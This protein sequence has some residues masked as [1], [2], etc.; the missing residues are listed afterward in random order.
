MAPRQILL[1]P[2]LG[3][4]NDVA[5]HITSARF[6]LVLL[7]YMTK[8]N[9]RVDVQ[10]IEDGIPKNFSEFSDSRTRSRLISPI[11]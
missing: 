1:E 6:R 8:R 5:G 3:L 4:N 10:K 7:F 2:Y 9:V 11:L